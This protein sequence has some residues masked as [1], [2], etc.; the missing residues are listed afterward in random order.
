MN[1]KRKILNLLSRIVRRGYWYNNTLFP[2]CKKFWSYKT[3]NTEVVN[4]GSTSGVYAFNYEDLDLKAANWALCA[5]PLLG[6]MAIL[7][8]YYSFL[9]AKKCTVI[10]PLCPFSSLS[11]SYNYFPDRYYSLLYC[12]SIPAYSFRRE[13]QVLAMK[14]NPLP[15][16]PLLAIFQDIRLALYPKKLPQLTEV[17]MERDSERWMK[18]WMKEFSI[19]DFSYPLS[20]VNRDGIED[21]AKTINEIITFCKERNILPV[22]VIPPVFHTLGEKFTLEIRKKVIDSLI[23]K[24][25]DK[26]VWY[27]NYMDDPDF[28]FDLSLF[29]NS[30]L[31]NEKGAKFFT[32]RVLKDLGLISV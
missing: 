29:R 5:N 12:S 24:V 2:D 13:Q 20:M 22:M 19:T 1:I 9:S 8:N 7:K 14:T 18:N 32:L 30:Y 16:Y 27:H 6:D 31:M 26:S 4:L 11:G 28:T 15:Y 10:L 17:Q 25:M 23:E 3:F 21:A